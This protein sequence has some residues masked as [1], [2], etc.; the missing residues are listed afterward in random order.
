MGQSK[1]LSFM[2]SFFLVGFAP[3]VEAEEKEKRSSLPGPWTAWS[4]KISQLG[5]QHPNAF[6]IARNFANLS[7]SEREAALI[8]SLAFNNLSQHAK[9]P[10][11]FEKLL[12]IQSAEYLASALNEIG[13]TKKTLSYLGL[14][15]KNHRVPL[16]AFTPDSP[17]TYRR[18]M[19]MAAA[20]EHFWELLQTDAVPTSLKGK[21][22][23]SEHQRPPSPLNGAE[24]AQIGKIIEDELSA[25]SDKDSAKHLETLSSVHALSRSAIVLLSRFTTPKEASS[26]EIAVV[27]GA[28][29]IALFSSDS[30]MEIARYHLS[31][32][33]ITRLALSGNL[34]TLGLTLASDLASIGIEDFETRVENAL[35]KINESL[36][37]LDLKLDQ[38]FSALRRE[39][40]SLR[41]SFLRGNQRL[42]QRVS[43]V[44]RQI[45]AQAIQ[46]DQ[47]MEFLLRNNL[48]KYPGIPFDEALCLTSGADP[49]LCSPSRHWVTALCALDLENDWRGRFTPQNIRSYLGCLGSTNPPISDPVQATLDQF[50]SQ[51]D[52]LRNSLV[53]RY[54][55]QLGG[56]EYD[57][58]K[59]WSAQDDV[60]N[61]LPF[62]NSSGI[63]VDRDQKFNLQACSMSSPSTEQMGSITLPARALRT[64][65]QKT[66]PTAFKA[67]QKL[68]GAFFTL[69]FRQV[70]Y[71]KYSSSFEDRPSWYFWTRTRLVQTVLPEILIQL[72]INEERHPEKGALILL[73]H[74]VTVSD[75]TLFSI[76]TEVSFKFRSAEPDAQT[77]FQFITTHWMDD[78]EVY[79]RT[80]Q[81]AP[82]PGIEII[83]QEALHPEPYG[84][85][86]SNSW[87]FA[88]QQGYF[89]P[90]GTA[91][92]NFMFDKIKTALEFDLNGEMLSRDNSERYA[93]F[94]GLV[95]PEQT[96]NRKKQNTLISRLTEEMALRTRNIRFAEIDIE[97]RLLAADHR[98]QEGLLYDTAV[99]RALRE[100]SA[101]GKIHA[102]AK[103]FPARPEFN[104]KFNEAI[105]SRLNDISLSDPGSL[106]DPF[107]E[108]R[109]K[110]PPIAVE[111]VQ[112]VHAPHQNEPT[113]LS[114]PTRESSLKNM[115]R[116]SEVLLVALD[117]AA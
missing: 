115:D 25:S 79:R 45:E 114:K 74:W 17:E 95:A 4:E 89:S 29:L 106:T 6:Q 86:L 62:L 19:A 12:S 56:N 51:L 91:V 20:E 94:L 96:F 48:K 42:I 39:I 54:K 112:S 64:Y 63:G 3:E 37:D 113:M 30:A 60:P 110:T 92:S 71:L 35:A 76:R 40:A 88:S 26:A 65:Y 41:A 50:N 61:V 15:G 36:H 49:I 44:S 90:I 28:E 87:E 108:L 10:T 84:I 34:L 103:A 67:L 18:S 16:T 83:S 105:V 104:S 66:I 31:K 75:L 98:F 46:S 93:V 43:K 22:S 21:L 116:C 57:P 7:S 102:A 80:D 52:Q 2:L 8:A 69:C 73:E 78:A 100:L 47:D 24:A 27:K 70:G 1:A 13:Y 117:Q 55:D 68:D 23:R 77:A 72:A 9:N 107:F 14:D 58:E 85:I 82:D 53:S 59:D 97:Q 111:A 99:Y 33:T 5:R 109:L 81:P 101:A 11:N 38:G 32:G